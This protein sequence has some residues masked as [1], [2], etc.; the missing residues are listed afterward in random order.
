MSNNQ[1]KFL[2]FR[3]VDAS[4]N[5]HA[6]GGLTFAY[7]EVEPGIIEHAHARCHPVDNFSKATARA[8]AGGRLLSPRFAKKFEGNEQQFQTLLEQ[9]VELFNQYSPMSMYAGLDLVR[10]YSGKRRPEAAAENDL[11]L[12]V[13][14]EVVAAAIA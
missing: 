2:H 4:G 10:K 1:T 5:I 9:D 3:Y 14:G 6:R 8:K 11:G 13:T 12:T 7:R